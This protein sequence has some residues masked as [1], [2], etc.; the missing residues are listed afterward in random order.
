M[1]T[2]GILLPLEDGFMAG[3]VK[4]NYRML[5]SRFSLQDDLSGSELFVLNIHLAAFDNGETRVKQLESVFEFAK[6]L[7]EKGH[8]V[9]IG[10][11]WNMRLV[12]TEFPHETDEE[13]LF[14]LRDLPADKVPVGWSIAADASI[15]SV[16]TVHKSY[17]KGENYVAVVDGFIVSP[18]VEIIS[19]ENVDLGF[20][21]SDHHPVKLKFKLNMDNQ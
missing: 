16:R 9:V 12:Q 11:D 7:H 10:G 17:V 19:I 4:R 6:K 20:E 3:V 18:N 8:F 14:W 13:F 1:E 5:V 15:P 2:T 21:N